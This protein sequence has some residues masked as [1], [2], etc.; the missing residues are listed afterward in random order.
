MS[1]RF[2]HRM[3]AIIISYHI[4]VDRSTITI[5]L[6]IRVST[7]LKGKHYLVYANANY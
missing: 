4:N 3:N 6:N 5:D 1:A 7:G 2:V